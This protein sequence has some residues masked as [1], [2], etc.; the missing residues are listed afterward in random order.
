[1]KVLKLVEISSKLPWV[2][3]QNEVNKKNEPGDVYKRRKEAG[4]PGPD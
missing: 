4:R 3:I 1:M 2:K